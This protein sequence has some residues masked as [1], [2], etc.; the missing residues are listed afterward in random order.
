MNLNSQPSEQ[1]ELFIPTKRKRQDNNITK[2]T[3]EDI[4]AWINTKAM[5]MNSG[6]IGGMYY[7]FENFIVAELKKHLALYMYNGLSPSPRV[8][9]KKPEW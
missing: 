1:Y 8:E 3:I 7:L 6:R 4:T 9:R 5:M 2:F